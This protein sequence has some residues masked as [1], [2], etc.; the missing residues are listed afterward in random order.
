MSDKPRD[1]LMVWFKLSS[2]R[3]NFKHQ[4]KG[5]SQFMLKHVRETC[6]WEQQKQ[7]EHV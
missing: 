3:S 2:N 5:I 7:Q 1:I 4:S 6:P